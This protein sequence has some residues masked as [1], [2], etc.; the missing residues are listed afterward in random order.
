MP[1]QVPPVTVPE[2]TAPIVGSPPVDRQYFTTG[3]LACRFQI[4]VQTVRTILAAASIAPAFHLNEI[5]HWD[6]HAML[7]L[8]K[9][10]RESQP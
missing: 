2:P 3:H 6:G 9:S 1:G 5:Q 8:A 10:L 4:P 7:A